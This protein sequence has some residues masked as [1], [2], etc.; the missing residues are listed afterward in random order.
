MVGKLVPVKGGVVGGIFHPRIG[1]KNT[2]YIP[3][4]VLA[5]WGVKKLPIPPFTGTSIPTIDFLMGVL[6][7]ETGPPK[8]LRVVYRET[9]VAHSL[10]PTAKTPEN[11]WLEYFLASFW[12]GPIVRDYVIGSVGVYN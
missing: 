11:G 1:R 10:K 12:D 6:S 3:L 9:R 7:D 5:F 2:T 4:I 8:I